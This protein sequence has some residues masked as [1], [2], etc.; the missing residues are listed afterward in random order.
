MTLIKVVNR[1]RKETDHFVNIQKF[2]QT[3]NILRSSKLELIVMI[4]RTHSDYTQ[5]MILKSFNRIDFSKEI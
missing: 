1:V 5:M 3:N 2:L 4:I